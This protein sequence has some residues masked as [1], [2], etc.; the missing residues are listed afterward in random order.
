LKI[1]AASLAW[2]NVLLRD[3]AS[4][5][6]YS[7]VDKKQGQTELPASIS[8]PVRMDVIVARIEA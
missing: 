7:A 4:G 3:A 8:L 1:D 6:A 5:N 2:V